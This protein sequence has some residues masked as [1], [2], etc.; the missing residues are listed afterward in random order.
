LSRAAA[1][2]DRIERGVGSKAR[3]TVVPVALI[4][5]KE[6]MSTVPLLALALA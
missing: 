3:L 2:L 6:G 4:P 1:T 5:A